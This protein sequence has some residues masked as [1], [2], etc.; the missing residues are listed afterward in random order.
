[1][2]DLQL[3]HQLADIAQQ[4]ALSRYGAVDLKI[5][6]KLDMTPV[7]DADKLAE[8]R[9]REHLDKVAPADGVIGE[10]FA[11]KKSS[12]NRQWILD[13]IDGTKNF[14]KGLPIWANLIA[15]R[16]DGVITT[17][18]VNAPAISRRWYG[19]AGHGAFVDEFIL[20]QRRKRQLFV[21]KVNKLSDS[22]FAFAEVVKQDNWEDRYEKFLALTNQVWRGRGFG[23]FWGHMLV[24]EGA[25][26]FTV[27]PKL[28]LWDM[29]ALEI[30]V[31]EAG[32][33][34]TNILGSDG[35][36]GPGAI[37]SNGLLHQDIVKALN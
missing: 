2:N 24:A 31:K 27:E 29:A 33:R 8:Q 15:L 12:N 23:D 6:G 18:I 32:G 7:S 4:I 28:A 34:F 17:G 36:D 37:A 1:V 11:E 10:E 16:I 30:I 20:D 14:I 26:D 9:I 35:I 19:S 21:S 13:P 25:V 3:A 5:T 22:S